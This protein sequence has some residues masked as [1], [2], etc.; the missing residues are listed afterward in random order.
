MKTRN[1][2]YGGT[3]SSPEAPDTNANGELKKLVL[4]DSADITKNRSSWIR[5]ILY[6]ILDSFTHKTEDR[7]TGSNIG[8]IGTEIES[9]ETVFVTPSQLPEVDKTTN[10][11]LTPAKSD[12]NGVLAVDNDLFVVTPVVTNR[13]NKRFVIN[14][15][16]AGVLFFKARTWLQSE[17]EDLIDTAIAA[18]PAPTPITSLLTSVTNDTLTGTFAQLNNMSYTTPSGATKKYLITAK[19][20][21]SM[22]AGSATQSDITIRLYNSTDS[23]T[24]DTVRMVVGSGSSDTGGTFY[25]TLTTIQELPASKEIKI[26]AQLTSGTNTSLIAAIAQYK[27]LTIQQIPN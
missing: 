25:T 14:F 1:E 10:D 8:V 3:F 17:I 20:G 26:E 23:V 22:N 7:A 18:I 24:Y 11:F 19:L 16:E 5:T 6:N 9:T 15:S 27:T 12:A 2:I 21:F 13:K 4:S